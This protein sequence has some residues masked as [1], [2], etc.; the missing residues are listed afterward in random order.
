MATIEQNT[1]LG[2][3]SSMCVGSM[4]KGMQNHST[5]GTC[6][7]VFHFQ[8]QQSLVR[9]KYAPSVHTPCNYDTKFEADS[10]SGHKVYFCM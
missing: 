2:L 3:P 6:V 10:N 5:D 8:Y 9:S 4:T 7:S 1:V